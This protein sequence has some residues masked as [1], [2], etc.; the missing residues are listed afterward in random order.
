MNYIS[1][2]QQLFTRDLEKLKTEL[3]TYQHEDHLWKTDAGI[4]NSAGNLT[5]HL[6]GN[7]NHFIGSLLGNT[8][9]VRNRDKEFSDK[10]IPRE[11]LI[12]DTDEVIRLVNAVLPTLTEEKLNE[13]FPVVL[14]GKELR[15]DLFLMHLLT[16]LSYH[17]GQINYHRRL[18]D[19]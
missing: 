15:T 8:G 18:L 2:L 6:I 14:A 9:Y 4:L 19:H 11:T 12:K 17:L 3:G 7:L 1:N 16:H 13:I 5:L 10:N